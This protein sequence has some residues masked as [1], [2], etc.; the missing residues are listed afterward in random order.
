MQAEEDEPFFVDNLEFGGS[1]RAPTFMWFDN[2]T[3]LSASIPALVL[4][5]PEIPEPP[6]EPEE[7]EDDEEDDDSWWPGGDGEDDWWS[8]GEEETEEPEPEEEAE[9]SET[10]SGCSVAASGSNPWLALVLL[11]LVGALRRKLH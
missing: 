9:W 3:Q 5:R 6:V 4:Q 11:S 7:D 2:H 10:G 1:V 8:D